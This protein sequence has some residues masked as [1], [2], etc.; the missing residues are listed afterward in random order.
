MRALCRTVVASG[1]KE[2]Q[3]FNLGCFP[4]F[5]YL[6]DVVRKAQLV[7]SVLSVVSGIPSNSLGDELLDVSD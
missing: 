7:E 5:L 4:R 2:S 1:R 3:G 6:L